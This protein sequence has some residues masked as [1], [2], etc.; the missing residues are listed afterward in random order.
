MQGEGGGSAP[1]GAWKPPEIHRFHWSRGRGD[2]AQ[3]APPLNTPLFR[4]YNGFCDAS[5]KSLI[6]LI[7]AQRYIFSLIQIFFKYLLS[8]PENVE[9]NWSLTSNS[10]FIIYICS[11]LKF[12][13]S[14]TLI[15]TKTY[16]RSSTSGC[17][18]TWIPNLEFETI[19][20]FLSSDV[21]F[22]LFICCSKMKSDE[23]KDGLTEWY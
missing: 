13:H 17:K 1:I 21:H 15:Y 10:N 14:R 16:Q 2:W 18:H 22:Q 23:F 20:H 11:T 12:N 8:I 9:R 19:S 6:F 7:F 3:I 4:I 5:F